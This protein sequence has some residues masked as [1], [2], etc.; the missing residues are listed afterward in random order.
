M[1][2]LNHRYAGAVPKAALCTDFELEAVHV[3]VYLAFLGVPNLWSHVRKSTSRAWFPPTVMG[4][5][6]SSLWNVAGLIHPTI[7]YVNL[8]FSDGEQT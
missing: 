3:H 8:N 7:L 2:L 4:A 1:H 6:T 5:G